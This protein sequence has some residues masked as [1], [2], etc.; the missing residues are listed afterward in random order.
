MCIL[1]IL[2]CGLLVLAVCAVEAD[3]WVQPSIAKYTSKSGDY[4]FTVEP[5]LVSHMFSFIEKSTHGAD[6]DTSSECPKGR[7]VSP[8]GEVV[9]ERKLVNE[10]APV[11]ALVS[12]EGRFV[13]TF[14]NWFSGGYGSDV[15]AIYGQ[16]GQVIL[17]FSLG[18]IVGYQRVSKF[19]R[20][21]SSRWWSGHHEFESEDVLLLSVLA[22]GSDFYS[23]ERKFDTVRIRLEDGAVLAQ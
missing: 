16:S 1:T 4:S 20:S 2:S 15:V 22:E 11:S 6:V 7:L 23:D 21:I 13:V 9:W 3:S 17:E 12:A 8:S 14:D 19:P 5:L 10:V 18:D